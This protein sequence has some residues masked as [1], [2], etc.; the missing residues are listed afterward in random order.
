MALATR[1]GAEK[2]GPPRGETG[3]DTG[4]RVEQW[5]TALLTCG[6]LAGVLYVAMTLFVGLLWDDYSVADQTISEL[7]A[8]DAPTRPLWMVLGTVYTVLIIAFGWVVW[9]TAPPNRA[10]R[11]V[12]MLLMIHAAFGY[13]WPPMHQRAVLAAS[14]PTW[15]DTLHIAW[16][17]VTGILFLFETGFGAAVFGR[18]FRV[19]SI[20]TMVIV[21]ASAAM[22][23]T[24]TSALQADLPTPWVG[25]WERVSSTAYML[26]IAVLA[27][28]L[29][30]SGS[31]QET[32][33]DGL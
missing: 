28:V 19:Y 29:L 1:V 13:F 30:R 7:S 16:T 2:H 9:T 20:A 32:G 18:R 31:S 10:Q 23:G 21:L 4:A 33:R 14:G 11:V 5:R 6:I 17:I 24:Y 27:V 26:W 3:I 12:G 8:I 22:T 25:L 15:T